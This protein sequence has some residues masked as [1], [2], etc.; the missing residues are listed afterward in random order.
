MIIF[1]SLFSVAMYNFF[2]NWWP[3]HEMVSLWDNTVHVPQSQWKN[4]SFKGLYIDLFTI[5]E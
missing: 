4:Y 1:N 2:F 5:V 3:Y